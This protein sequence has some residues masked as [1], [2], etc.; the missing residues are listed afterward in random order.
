M[1]CDP[2]STSTLLIIFCD[3][4]VKGRY[5]WRRFVLDRRRGF[6]DYSTVVPSDG[7]RSGFR[8]SV[9]AKGLT[10]VE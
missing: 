7:W 6:T 1:S 5:V 3:I 2:G 10:A 4:R 8:A 9:R